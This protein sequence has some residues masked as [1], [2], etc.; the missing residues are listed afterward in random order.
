MITQEEL[1]DI[2]KLLGSQAWKL[3]NEIIDNH[4][5][6]LL[7]LENVPDTGEAVDLKVEIQAR[8]K[9][10]EKL[11]AILKELR[12]YGVVNRKVGSPLLRSMK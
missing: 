2:Q 7:S 12:G 3:V 8:R 11:T 10:A 9:A 5:T 1:A 6:E 4:V